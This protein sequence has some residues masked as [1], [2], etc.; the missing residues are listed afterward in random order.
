MPDTFTPSTP[1]V[2]G[3]DP[4][5]LSRDEALVDTDLYIAAVNP[6]DVVLP[7]EVLD[8]AAASEPGAKPPTPSFDATTP[9]VPWLTRP[10]LPARRD[11]FWS[12]ERR[13]LVQ[14]RA[15]D[16]VGAIG[17]LAVLAVPMGIVAILV[18]L[19]SK[20]PAIFSQQRVGVNR[21][22]SRRRV[23]GAHERRRRSGDR[24]RSGTRDGTWDGVEKRK[25]VGYGRTFTLYKFRTMRT[26]AE[27]DGRARLATANDDRIT[28]LGR[29]LR[30]TRIDEWPQLIN[31]IRGEMSLV[32]PRPER[33]ELVVGLVE[34]IPGFGS[35]TNLL[36]G[37]TGLAQIE[38]GYTSETA[39]FAKKAAYDDLYLQT[40]CLRND[41]K[42][43]IKT[44][45]VVVTG[46][47]A[48]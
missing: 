28:R 40:C 17:L 39:S 47:G 41:V 46:K 32:G 44:V 34:E 12:L 33:P 10:R 45:G 7:S 35:R 16:L 8:A 29:I 30:K 11:G 38:H 18:K 5:G 26:D 6:P 9:H 36:P 21:R 24:S 43:L 25:A 19:D 48:C 27:A 2:S 20:G 1:D 23:D 3:D 31:V 42:I 13:R 15:I 4:V 14:K 22:G 37:L